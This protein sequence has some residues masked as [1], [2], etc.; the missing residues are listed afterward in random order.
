MPIFCFLGN[1]LRLQKQNE[2]AHKWMQEREYNQL[3][4]Y[5]LQQYLQAILG[6]IIYIT[7]VIK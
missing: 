2:Q 5:Q 1:L 4:I 3:L 7:T 6:L